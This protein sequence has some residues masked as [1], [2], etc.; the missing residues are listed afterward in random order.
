LGVDEREIHDSAQAQI[1]TA[2]SLP[3]VRNVCLC[4][5]AG[6]AQAAAQAPIFVKALDKDNLSGDLIWEL[7]E[8]T[9]G[10]LVSGE[11]AAE[12]GAIVSTARAPSISYF[13]FC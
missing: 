11:A 12:R 8:D 2:S 6:T 3:L 9:L 10:T 4:W 13:C 7:D 1:E 5:T